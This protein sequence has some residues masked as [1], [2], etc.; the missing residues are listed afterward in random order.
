MA[1]ARR[2]RC[3]AR[4]R[5]GTCRAGTGVRSPAGARGT[6]PARPPRRHDRAHRRP[7]RPTFRQEG[8]PAGRDL[9]ADDLQPLRGRHGRSPDRRRRARPLPAAQ[10]RTRGAAP[11]SDPAPGPRPVP[12]ASGALRAAR[13]RLPDRVRPGLH[14]LRSGAGPD[15][16]P[17]PPPRSSSPAPWH[18]SSRPGVQTPASCSTCSSRPPGGRPGA[19][20]GTS[21]SGPPPRPSGR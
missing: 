21:P 13:S 12:P 16:P 20:S 6:H 2:A 8:R 11:R 1:R 4:G 18:P 3:R 19:G 15:R 9:A 14:V 17:I 10:P 5:P 7:R